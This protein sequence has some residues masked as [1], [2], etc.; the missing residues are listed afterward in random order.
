MIDYAKIFRKDLDDNLNKFL[1]ILLSDEVDA[2]YGSFLRGKTV[3]E[4][5][6]VNN[7][8]RLVKEDAYSDSFTFQWKKFTNT[9]L[10]SAQNL[11]LTRKEVLNKIQVD[12]NQLKGKFILDVGVGVGRHAEHFCEAGAYVIG[13]DLSNSVEQAEYNLKKYKNVVLM[14]GDLFN[15]PFRINCFDLVYSVGV[16]HH[17]PDWRQ[18]LEKI[19]P[20]VRKGGLL[21][22]WLY[23]M[24]FGRRDEWIPYTSKIEKKLFLNFCNFL[25]KSRRKSTGTDQNP[26][27]LNRLMQIHFP[28]AVH[29]PTFDRSLL[30]L[31]DG[32]SP[33]Y[34][35]FLRS[36]DIEE[37]MKSLGFS[38]RRGQIEASCVGINQ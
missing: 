21:S 37:K 14:Q 33:T 34:H 8:L 10:D 24:G 4:I 16:L 29:H 9:Q 12:P 13:V 22:V 3:G 35:D 5:P 2:A 25:I 19:A 11:D 6:V 36:E 18:G 15:L 30:A 32:Y 7:V 31:F 27:Y 1:N 38:C 23:G 17:T 26:T 28:F 20:F